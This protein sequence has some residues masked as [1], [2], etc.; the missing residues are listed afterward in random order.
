MVCNW[1]MYF[2]HWCSMVVKIIKKIIRPLF[3]LLY[4]MGVITCDRPHIT[5][6]SV[7]DSVSFDKDDP[8]KTIIISKSK[9]YKLNLKKIDLSFD[10]GYKDN[11]EFAKKY[12]IDTGK[13]S[14]L[15]VATRF[16]FEDPWQFNFELHEFL[17]SNNQYKIS[18]F[19][20]LKNQLKH[21]ELEKQK[22]WFKS[23]GWEISSSSPIPFLSIMELRDLSHSNF[24]EIALHG[25]E[26]ISYKHLSLKNAIIDI[27]KSKLLFLKNNINF[28]SKKFAFPYGD[29]PKDFKTEKLMK[30]LNLDQVF[31]TNPF[32]KKLII[33]RLLFWNE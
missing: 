15:F 11:I 17:K 20:K 9:F 30:E 29:I 7:G 33:G 10:D 28:N 3:N 4:T 25:H 6:H 19:D 12:F 8:N 24:I 23:R 18:D 31:G 14:T 22:L 26:H 5:L 21:M 2:L 27:N 16:I 1:K 13:K 32:S